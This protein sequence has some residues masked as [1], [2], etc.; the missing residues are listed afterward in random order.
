MSTSILT[1]SGI[2]FVLVPPLDHGGRKRGVRAR[3]GLAR[4]PHWELAAE[5]VEAR[6]V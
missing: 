2:T 4:E 3:V 1:S 6:F 5:V